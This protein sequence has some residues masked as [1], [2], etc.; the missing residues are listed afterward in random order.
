MSDCLRVGVLKLCACADLHVLV[1][2]DE[3]STVLAELTA[4]P[5][6]WQPYLK[7]FFQ[8][9]IPPQLDEVHPKTALGAR[10]VIA[11]KA[12]T[13]RE[14]SLQRFIVPTDATIRGC[15]GFPT[16]GEHSWSKR[17]EECIKVCA[18]AHTPQH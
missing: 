7:A 2:L 13:A 12:I 11:I 17:I 4:A 16:A 6:I 15:D 10:Q 1:L 5:S 3:S 8:A 14:R 18:H 9:E